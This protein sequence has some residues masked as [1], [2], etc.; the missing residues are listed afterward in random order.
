MKQGELPTI[1]RLQR[2]F[3]HKFFILHNGWELDNEA[4]LWDGRVF[5][6]SH[7]VVYEMSDREI[8]DKIIET[9]CS[10]Y[11]LKY[12]LAAKRKHREGK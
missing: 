10:L 8:E 1:E 11:G 2:E 12:A 4:W 9:G 5:T 3:V 7:D 6:T